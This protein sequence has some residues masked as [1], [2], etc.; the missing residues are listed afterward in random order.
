M[1]DILMEFIMEFV[2]EAFTDILGER[3]ELFINTRI[4]NKYLRGVLNVLVLVLLAAAGVGLA[5]GLLLLIGWLV[6]A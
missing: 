2:P 4:Q 3:W 1:L 6:C 5:F